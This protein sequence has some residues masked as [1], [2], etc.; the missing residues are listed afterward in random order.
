MRIFKYILLFLFTVTIFDQ[1]LSVSLEYIHKK[2]FTGQSGGKIN[3]FLKGSH[4]FLAIGNSRCAHHI[5]PE[6]I[7]SN[8]FNLSHNGLGLVFQTG[9]I[10]FIISHK[11]SRVDTI[12]L[13]IDHSEIFSNKNDHDTDIQSLKY[14]YDKNKWIQEKIDGVHKFEFIKYFFSSYKWN[15]RLLSTINNFIKSQKEQIP[16]R[17]YVPKFATDRDSINVTWSHNRSEPLKNL[18]LLINQSVKDHIAHLKKIC[19]SKNI[20][21]ICFTSPVFNPKNDN[22]QRNLVLKK[23][24]DSMD[25]QYLNYIDIYNNRKELKSIWN[26][27]DN[28]HLNH[29]GAIIFTHILKTDLKN[30]SH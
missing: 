21:L 19:D 24:F 14:F 20:V 7:S 12:L 11:D 29:D 16:P 3:S 28:T 17:G 22:S 2:T 8:S 6:K 18:S 30:I 27:N 10:D 13:H 9:L 25:I 5:I 1:I 23:F 15:G 4:S 26:W